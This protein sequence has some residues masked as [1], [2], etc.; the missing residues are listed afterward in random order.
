MKK[1]PIKLSKLEIAGLAALQQAVIVANKALQDGFVS[2][3]L[4]LGKSYNVGDDGTVVEVTP[5]D[6]P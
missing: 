4:E 6:V 5:E 2:V 3:G 1:S